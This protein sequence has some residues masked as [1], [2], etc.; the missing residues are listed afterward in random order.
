[1]SLFYSVTRHGSFLE[2]QIM[3]SEIMNKSR[4]QETR[5]IN[6]RS[7]LRGRVFKGN[8]AAY[9]A[10]CRHFKKFPESAGF[11]PLWLNVCLVPGLLHKRASF[12]FD[13]G[14]VYRGDA[15]LVPVE[16]AA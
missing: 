11:A 5:C 2:D 3:K 8:K 9:D 16:V 12:V 14:K 10:A 13:G 1:V 7:A 15:T 6:A 4:S